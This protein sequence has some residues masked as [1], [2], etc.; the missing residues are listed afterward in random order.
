MSLWWTRR[1]RAGRGRGVEERTGGFPVMSLDQ[2]LAKLKTNSYSDVDLTRAESALQS[3]AV[4]AAVDLIASIG[5]ELPVGVFRGAGE[6]RTELRVPSWL[7]DPDGSGYGLPDW[8]YR[9]LMSWLL[10]G[11]LFGDEL[12]IGPG[13]FL[14]QVELLHPDTVTG[15]L[16]EGT[17]RWLVNGRPVSSPQTFR[18]WRV[19]PVAGYVKGLSPIELHATTIGLSLTASKFGLQWFK[20][21][22]HPNALLQNSEADLDDE[23]TRKVKDKFLAAVRGHREPLVVGRGWDYKPLQISPEES[24]FLETQKYSQAECAR[25]FGPGIAEILGYGSG[26][27]T[28]SNIIDRDISLLKYAVGRWLRR[29]ERVLSQFLPRP[30]YVK[31]NR[32]ALL[33]T[34]T[35]QRFQAHASALANQWK[36]V[37]EVRSVEELAPVPWGDAPNMAA[38]GAGAAGSGQDDDEPGA[39]DP[40]AD[41]EE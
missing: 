27:M 17:V 14:R 6:D 37:N 24:Q 10:R 36:V 18:H 8:S 28:Y 15:S 38:A 5:S 25:I 4:Y 2:L 40:D 16:D 1:T 39:A 29:L 21:G 26:S 34:N 35:L 11:N 12:E 13:G 9:A 7:E 32:D 20:D 41:Q 19:N 31:L 22:A 3:V 23:Q 30:Q 33:E